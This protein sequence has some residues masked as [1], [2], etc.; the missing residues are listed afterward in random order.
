MKKAMLEYTIFSLSAAGIFF[1][2]ARKVISD[3]LGLAILSVFVLI[4]I[5]RNFYASLKNFLRRKG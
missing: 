4:L 2:I 3:D 5:N 1:G